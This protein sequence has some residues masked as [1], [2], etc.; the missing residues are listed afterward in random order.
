M[1]KTTSKEQVGVLY[2]SLQSKRVVLLL[3]V[4][5]GLEVKEVGRYWIHNDC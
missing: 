4:V 1:K 5:V 2:H 3:E